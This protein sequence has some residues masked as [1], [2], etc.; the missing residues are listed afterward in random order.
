MSDKKVDFLHET[1]LSTTDA[2][3]HRVYLHPEDVQ[4]KFRTRRTIFYTLLIFIYL[5]LPWIHIDG[6]QSILIDITHREFTFFGFTFFGHDIPL[7]FFILTLW[8]FAF[9]FITAVWGRVWCGFACPQTVFIDAIFSRIERWIEGKARQRKELEKAPWT[10]QKFFK[11]TFKWLLF[12]LVSLHIVH[13]F[14]GYF[15]G[16]RRLFWMSLHSPLDNWGVFVAM[17]IGVAI[18][19]LDFGWFR[20][21]FCIIV[22][23]YGRIQSVMMDENSLVVAYD[24]KRGEP[25]RS[26][27]VSRD[28]EGDCINC[29]ACV[30]VCPTGID[31][32]NGTQLEC[33]ACTACMDMCDEIMLKVGKPQGL[34]RY[35]SENNLKGGGKKIF[36]GRILVYLAVITLLL[37]GLIYSLRHQTIL[38]VVYTRSKNPYQIISRSDSDP[39]IM[40]QLQVH[41]SYNIQESTNIS[42]R[43]STLSSSDLEIIAPA[44]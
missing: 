1:R 41:L 13:S 43:T 14:L 5:I 39:V 10:L 27:G 17:L 16:T 11:K 2:E 30:K 12:L 25:R 24:T 34:I 4:G 33:I 20:E 18:V 6:K 38:D 15:V 35:D 31:I 32:R 3:G 21:Q 44:S 28:A 19:L 8:V 9:A 36:T 22:C 7:L 29:F 42:I 37:G 26:V 23:P 40:N